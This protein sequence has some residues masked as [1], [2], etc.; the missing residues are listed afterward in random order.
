MERNELEQ[1]ILTLID[2][3]PEFIKFI[4]NPTEEMCLRA[5]KRDGSTL[6]HCPIRTAKIEMDA[7]EN[8]PSVV[9]FIENPTKE[10]LDF[11][12][13]H[14]ASCL[15]K[16]IID[17][18]SPEQL[19]TAISKCGRVLRYIE[20]PSQDLVLSAVNTCGDAI[21]LLEN[22]TKELLMKAIHNN[23]D[24]IQHISQEL[25]ELYP[26]IVVEAFRRGCRNNS[27]KVQINL[28]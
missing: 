22:P 25:Q 1:S 27:I 28:S 16:E 20:N 12:I 18:L 17:K 23:C 7:L 11:V 9:R 21:K 2:E 24:C 19:L 14:D 8:D 13:E 26:E 15:E 4:R 3:R 10:Q 6:E 5:V